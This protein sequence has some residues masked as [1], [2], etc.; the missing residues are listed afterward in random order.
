[1]LF[2]THLFNSSLF[3]GGQI[4]ATVYS[5]DRLS[6]EGF[7]LSDGTNTVL[8]RLTA[9]GPTRQVVGG[10]IPRGDGRYVTADY[11]RQYFITAEGYVKAST[12]AA[13]DAYLDTIRKNLRTREGDLQVID[14]NGT[15]KLFTATVDNFDDVF[16]ERQYYHLTICPFRIR[17]QCNTPF[18]KARDYTDTFDTLTS[19]PATQTPFNSGTYKAQP[20]V[21]MVFN[22]ASSVT[23]VAVANSTTGESITY[24]GSIAAGDVLIFDSEQKT[25][26]KNGTAVSYSGT[27]PSLDVG[28]N[29]VRYTIAGTFSVDTTLKHKQTYI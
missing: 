10:E 16:A 11:F 24:A 18:G 12:A 20:V 14:N 6:F 3:N 13:L 2:N 7:S 23:S 9:S 5:A 27:F 26:T 22:S 25:V 19:S 8:S 21:I 15:V 4:G 29:S 28:A 1:M 17:F